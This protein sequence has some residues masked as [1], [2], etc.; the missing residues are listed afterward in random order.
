VR[1]RDLGLT[2]KLQTG[3]LDAIT[4]VPGVQV[5][6]T[7]LIQ[8]DDVRTGV[9]I[10]RPHDRS[11]AEAPLF[12]GSHRLN[13]NGELTGLEWIRESGMLTSP[14]A[15]TNTYS[16]GVVRDALAGTGLT[17]GLPVV[18]ET[19]DGTLNDI[20]GMHVQTAHALEALQA[21]RPGPVAEGNVGGGTGMICHEFKGGIGTSSRRTGESAGGYTVGVL[22]QANHGSRERFRVHGLPVGEVLTQDRIPLPYDDSEGSIIVIV[23]TDAPL[24]PTQCDRLAQRA[25]FG[26]ART[27]GMGEQSS[28]DLILAFSTGNRNLTIGESFSP[29]DGARAEEVTLQLQMLS[30]AY[31]NSL[32]EAVIEA[33]EGAILN[34]LLGAETMTGRG[35]AV[36]HALDE[37]LLQEALKEIGYRP[38]L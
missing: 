30:D 12:A 21:A 23:G 38:W 29:S 27:G 19:W 7:T 8:G 22:V 37:D 25:S 34:A 18:G 24:L 31:I 1:A 2:G 6:H 11:L 36:V 35:G 9:T 33:T 20:Q 15:I 5:G 4:D 14:I 13:G 3:P 10:I 32:F 16:V 28:G 17:G 26:I